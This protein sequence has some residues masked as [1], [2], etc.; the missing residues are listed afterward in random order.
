MTT[1]VLQYLH[2]FLP[3]IKISPLP[4]RIFL[5]T[6]KALLVPAMKLSLFQCG[7]I[8][9]LILLTNSSSTLR[10]ATGQLYGYLSLVIG[11]EIAF[12]NSYVLVSTPQC[13]LEPPV[14]IESPHEGL[15][16]DFSIDNART[17]DACYLEPYKQHRSCL[18]GLGHP[19]SPREG[20]GVPVELTDQTRR[21]DGH[22]GLPQICAPGQCGA[23]HPGERRLHTRLA[24]CHA[25]IWYCPR[26]CRGG[27]CAN[28]ERLHVF[29]SSALRQC[30]SFGCHMPRNII[31]VILHALADF[32][33]AYTGR[34]STR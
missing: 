17:F 15:L 4:E 28:S 1:P 10:K 22:A 31:D 21:H 24:F 32:L 5:C 6:I 7:A 20:K 16:V 2:G 30:V 9:V 23:V 18:Y 33:S 25:E 29:W 34:I 8:G 12:I 11:A 27:G 26:L 19:L 3:E 13:L 14:F